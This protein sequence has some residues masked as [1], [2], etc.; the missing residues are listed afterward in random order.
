MPLGCLRA[1]KS[2]KKGGAGPNR[3][4]EVNESAALDHDA[5]HG[6]K[7]QSGSF[8]QFLGSKE[9]FENSTLGSLVYSSPGIVDD[10][11]NVVAGKYL[12]AD[13]F[14]LRGHFEVL[15]ADLDHAAIEHRVARV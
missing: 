11:A 6:R 5:V 12:A 1:R 9:G 4:F 13:G 8:A 7:A 15:G 2:N 3:A 10:Q 14:R